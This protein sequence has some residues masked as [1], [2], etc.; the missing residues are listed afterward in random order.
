MQFAHHLNVVNIY[1]RCLRNP[2]R[3]SRVTER[4]GNT[5]IRP[6]TPKSD[7]DLEVSHPEHGFCTSSQC[8]KHLCQV[9]LRNP[10]RGSRVTDGKGNKVTWL[11]HVVSMWLKFVSGFFEILQG[12]QELQSGREIANNRWTDRGIDGHRGYNIIHPLGRIQTKN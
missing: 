4:K 7:L 1:V 12:V 5:V 6:L 2:S 9:F 10:S 8:G 11:L 3:G